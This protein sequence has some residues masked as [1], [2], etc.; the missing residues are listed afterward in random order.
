MGKQ[1]N[2]VVSIT[3]IYKP[4]GSSPDS[5]VFNV[6]CMFANAGIGLN[7]NGLGPRDRGGNG[8]KAG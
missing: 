6:L 8:A 7:L 2:A 1:G 3:V 5:S 4:F